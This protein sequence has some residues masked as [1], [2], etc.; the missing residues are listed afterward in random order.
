[1]KIIPIFIVL[2]IAISLIPATA[3]AAQ[4]TFSVNVQEQGLPTNA[5]WSGYVT[6]FTVTYG[7]NTTSFEAGLFLTNGTW[8]Y[9]F[10]DTST[11]YPLNPSGYF[12][13]DNAS[14]TLVAQYVPFSTTTKYYLQFTSNL[15]GNFTVSI[16][17]NFYT[18]KVI[19]ISLVSSNYSY[20]A[21]ASGYATI[22]SSV[23]LTKNTSIKL[24]FTVQPYTGTAET[25]NLFFQSVGGLAVVADVFFMA[26]GFVL[27]F[28]VS[29]KRNEMNIFV[30]VG[31][32]MGIVLVPVVLGFMEIWIY[33]LIILFAVG[34]LLI[35][36]LLGG[37]NVTE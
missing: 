36:S 5:R 8:K 15:A 27:A 35:P 25:L 22:S 11:Y 16:N 37:R 1:M 30:F 4:K 13:V 28:L 29:R 6:N 21:S 14:Y 17:N 31:I 2:L 20:S 32:F 3:L 18:G 7:W 26:L 23:F 24:N 12:T 34:S 19:N 33:I 10:N 9:Q